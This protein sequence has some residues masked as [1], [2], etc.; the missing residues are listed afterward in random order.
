MLTIVRFFGNRQLHTER[1]CTWLEPMAIIVLSMKVGEDQTNEPGQGNSSSPPQGVGAVVKPIS[2]S[3]TVDSSVSHSSA[4]NLPPS[5]AIVEKDLG[6]TAAWLS[7]FTQVSVASVV[8]VADEL[9]R[10]PCL[11]VHDP[12]FNLGIFDNVILS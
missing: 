5:A 3:A 8:D 10:P 11:Q 2:I 9:G 12:R 6:E 4:I 1:A 7:A